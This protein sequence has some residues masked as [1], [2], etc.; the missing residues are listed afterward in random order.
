MDEIVAGHAVVLLEM[1][2]DGLNGRTSFHAVFDL[3]GGAAFLASGVDLALIFWRRVVAAASSIGDDTI[4]GIADDRLHG[5][6]D[7]CERV[8]VIRVT[9]QRRDVGALPDDPSCFHLAAARLRYI[10]G[11]AWST[12]RYMNMRPLYQPQV[13]VTEAAVF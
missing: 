6:D 3:R 10:A 8:A 4:E 13:S 7:D 2:A 11:T 1:A 9:G 5:G 12:K